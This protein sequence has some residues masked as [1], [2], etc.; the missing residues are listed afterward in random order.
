VKG[1]FEGMGIQSL[2]AE[3]C[4]DDGNILSLENYAFVKSGGLKG[5]PDGGFAE[6]A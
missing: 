3:S 5:I 6:N 2:D 4:V 1:L